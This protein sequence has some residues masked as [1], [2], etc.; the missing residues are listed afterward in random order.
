MKAKKKPRS[1]RVASDDLLGAT[2]TT[3]ANNHGFKAG[4]TVRIELRD[5]RWWMRLWHWVLRR[6]SPVKY[7]FHSIASVDDDNTFTIS[8]PNA[9]LSGTETEPTTKRDA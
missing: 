5:T 7:E 3:V 2:T 9:M 4:D 6:P 1:N 8:P